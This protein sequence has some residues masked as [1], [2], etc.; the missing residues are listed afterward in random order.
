MS[1][2]ISFFL[3]FFLYVSSF[4]FLARNDSAIV[5]TNPLLDLP[6]LPIIVLLFDFPSDGTLAVSRLCS[7]ADVGW[8]ADPNLHNTRNPAPFVPKPWV[9]VTLTQGSY[10]YGSLLVDTPYS[11]GWLSM[12][13]VAA[14]P[15]LKNAALVNKAGRA[16]NPLPV[17]VSQAF[18]EQAAV[19]N[20]GDEFDI[21]DPHGEYAWPA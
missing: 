14:N 18:I 21:S 13:V 19:V 5:A 17:A 7:K 6:G 15:A 1:P 16:V 11:F 8:G 10:G 9:E 4:P 3:F 12:T 20:D 2:F